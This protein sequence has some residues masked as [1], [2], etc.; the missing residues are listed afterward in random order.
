MFRGLW[1]DVPVVWAKEIARIIVDYSK[2][3]SDLTLE[4]VEQVAKVGDYSMVEFVTRT[5][6]ADPIELFLAWP[7]KE[8]PE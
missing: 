7:E 2:K 5:L 1:K 3:R 6:E 4:L 8:E